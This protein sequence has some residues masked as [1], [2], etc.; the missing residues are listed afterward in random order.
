M[1]A[2]EK[3]QK[4]LRSQVSDKHEDQVLSKLSKGDSEVHNEKEE[5]SN[6]PSSDD[7]SRKILNDPSKISGQE[8]KFIHL[9]F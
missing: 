1:Q 3:L 5:G 4:T 7:L 8:S 2:M 9:G 6:G